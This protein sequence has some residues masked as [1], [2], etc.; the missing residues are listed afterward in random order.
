MEKFRFTVQLETTS[1]YPHAL[2]PTEYVCVLQH[3]GCV[4]SC[5]VFKMYIRSLNFMSKEITTQTGKVIRHKTTAMPP[6]VFLTY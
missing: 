3:I 1:P 2:C 5:A 4:I 6:S